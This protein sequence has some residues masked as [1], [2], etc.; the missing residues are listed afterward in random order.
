MAHTQAMDA[1]D[2]VA[3]ILIVDDSPTIRALLRD[4]LEADGHAVEESCDG[5]QAIERLSLHMTDIVLL[6]LGLP[7]RNGL[8]VLREIRGRGWSDDVAVLVV[9]S[10]PRPRRAELALDLGAVDYLAKPFSPQLVR[11]RVRNARRIQTVTRDLKTQN[12]LLERVI[13]DQEA[14]L[15]ER[16]QT[17]ERM[18]TWGRILENCHNEIYIFAADTLQ[19][20]H[21]NRSAMGNLHFQ[22][23]EWPRLCLLDVQPEFTRQGFE[24]RI[25]PLADDRV[26]AIEYETIH[27][28]KDGS[29]Y[30]VSVNVQ[31]TIFEGHSAYVAMMLDVS[32]HKQAELALLEY[33]RQLLTARAEQERQ[34]CELESKAQALR[35]ASEAAEQANRSK[36]EFLANMSHEIRTPLTAILGYAEVLRER[37]TCSQE[38]EAATTVQRNGEHLLAIINDILDLSKIES[39]RLELERVRCSISAIVEE[40]VSFL[41]ERAQSKGLSLTTLCHGQIPEFIETDP[42]RLRQIILN[43]VG[44]AVKFTECGPIEVIV[45]CDP[46]ETTPQPLLRVEVVDSGIGMSH[47]HLERIFDPFMQAD[48]S[49]SRKYGGSG[50]GLSISKRLAQMLGGDLT[51]ASQLGRGSRFCCTVS[52][53]PLNGVKL[54]SYRPQP[55]IVG[56]ETVADRD[57]NC[58]GQLSECKILLAEDGPDNRRLLI[59]ILEKMGA[60][61]TIAEDGV[62]ACGIYARSLQHGTPFDLV[63]MDMQMPNMDGYAASRHLRAWGCELPIIALTAHAMAG[64]RDRCLAAGCNA[65]LAKP[66]R[67]HELL[68]TLKYWFSVSTSTLTPLEY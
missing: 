57:Y 23:G 13:R 33:N 63:L 30:P 43:L 54:C 28:R 11:A 56:S 1:Q 12:R 52:P 44:N 14:A 9:T 20:L 68:K 22:S 45:S 15:C 16:N 66:I 48:A 67:R 4:A 64:D 25:A 36:S 60:R 51:V 50:L 65:Y 3:R 31:K 29:R 46:A 17:R 37:L 2:L 34:N 10:D 6:D 42:T 26:S 58:Q 7:H 27:C 55:L 21:L 32:C 24:Q 39:G 62:E 59:L 35:Q 53:G 49:T 5:D 41:R 8:E 61:V 38:Q 19:F 18:A 47:E 40:S